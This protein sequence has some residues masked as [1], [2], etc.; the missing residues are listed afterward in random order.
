MRSYF[1]QPRYSS[2]SEDE[3]KFLGFHY[4]GFDTDGG[5]TPPLMNK[6]SE[7]CIGIMSDG[8]NKRY[9]YE[10][11]IVIGKEHN[12]PGVVKYNYG[13]CSYY[14]HG[15]NF[16]SSFDSDDWTLVGNIHENTTEEIKSNATEPKLKPEAG[17]IHRENDY[18]GSKGLPE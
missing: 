18:D 15:E 3:R 9:L 4:W 8:E 12:G 16:M 17:N 14:I 13:D 6:P 11:D 10:G 2:F 7:N 5:Y 1:R